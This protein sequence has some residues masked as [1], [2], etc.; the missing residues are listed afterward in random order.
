MRKRLKNAS[1]TAAAARGE[2]LDHERL[3]DM[4]L[5]DNEFVHAPRKK[6]SVKIASLDKQYWKKRFT[7]ARRLLGIMPGMVSIEA[8]KAVL[9]ALPQGDDEPEDK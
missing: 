3:A 2:A 4:G 1:D 7:G 6:S 5:G 9:Q 8:A